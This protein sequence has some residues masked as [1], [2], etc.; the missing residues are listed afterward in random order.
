MLLAA[1]CG[2]CAI[3]AFNEFGE[4]YDITV[5]FWGNNMDCKEEFDRRLGALET[6]NEKLNKGRE[7]VVVPYDNSQHTPLACESCFRARSRAAAA[8]ATQNGFDCYSTSLTVSPHK[9]SAVINA[10]GESAGKDYG[11]PFISADLKKRGG[12]QKTIEVSKQLGIYRQKYCGCK[13]AAR[14]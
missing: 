13:P 8:F 5:F 12:F 10:I 2:P 1:C 14:F 9:N 11:V 3:A 6:V 4:S 7:M